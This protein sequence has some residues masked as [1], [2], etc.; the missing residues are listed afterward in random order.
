MCVDADERFSP[1]LSQCSFLK[2]VNQRLLHTQTRRLHFVAQKAKL[3][4][5]LTEAE[6][7]E[8]EEERRRE[9]R[10][11]IH[12]VTSRTPVNEH[13]PH[14]LILDYSSDYGPFSSP[15]RADQSATFSPIRSTILPFI[16]I[17]GSQQKQPR[18]PCL[19]PLPDSARCPSK[20]QNAWTRTRR[21]TITA[22]SELCHERENQ[23]RWHRLLDQVDGAD[24]AAAAHLPPSNAQ[25]QQRLPEQGE[26]DDEQP[27]SQRVVFRPSVHG[28][29]CSLSTEVGPTSRRC[30]GY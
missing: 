10:H 5:S 2:R 24:D 13:H 27:D 8:G 7:S 20:I 26:E 25:M 1:S 16:C 4:V 28:E 12:T 15:L 14:T 29:R 30:P 6:D 17:S 21:G 19:P 22:P 11:D 23:Q 18:G 3:H 9:Q